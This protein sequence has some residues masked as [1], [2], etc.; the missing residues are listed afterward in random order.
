MNKTLKSPITYLFF[1]VPALVLLIMFFIYPLISSLYYSF[2]NWNGI[3]EHAKY[4][5]FQNYTK[6]LTDPVFWNSVKNNGYFILFSVFIQVPI[7]IVASL[8]IANVKKLQGLYKTAIFMPTVMST[9]VIG[10][11]WGFIYNYDVGLLNKIIVFFGGAPIDWLGSSKTAMLSILITNCWQ[12]SGFYIITILAAILTIPKE[13]D[14]AAEIDGATGF[15]RV[16]TITMPLIVPVISVV[17]MLSVAG[18]MKAADIIIVMTKGGPAGSTDVMATY[19][20]KYAITNFKYGY[21]NAL[22]FLIFIF[23]MAITVI[24]QVLFARRAERVDY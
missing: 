13:L 8:M 12:W 14:E 6:A 11:L 24:Y 3:S 1:I 15:Q 18:S 5:G 23:T 22:S 16:R 19:M 4:I 2:T 9:A 20:I 10:I 17:I 21:G 7:T